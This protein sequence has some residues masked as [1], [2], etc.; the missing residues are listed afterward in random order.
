MLFKAPEPP[1]I[2]EIGHHAM[3]DRDLGVD[4][5]YGFIAV[6]GLLLRIRAEGGRT[7]RQ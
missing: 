5:E 1:F 4:V 7:L 6:L 3:A 2:R